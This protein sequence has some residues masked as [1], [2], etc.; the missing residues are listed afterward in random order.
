MRMLLGMF[1]VERGQLR[2]PGLGRL[3]V[4]LQ[5]VLLVACSNVAR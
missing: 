4:G 1:S 3:F 5:G 2:G